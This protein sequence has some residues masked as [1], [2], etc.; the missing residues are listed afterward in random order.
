ML[1]VGGL[2]SLRSS[3]ARFHEH[4]S[5]VLRQLGWRPS[6]ADAD[7]WMKRV[8]D[9]WE[10]LSTYVDDIL[11][12]AKYPM[13]VINKFKSFYTLKGIGEPEYYLGGEIAITPDTK[14]AC[15]TETYIERAVTKYEAI[16]DVPG[17]RLYNTPMAEDYHPC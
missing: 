1:I 16:F 15:S 3:G 11:V 8:D 5:R 6:K 9:H 17:F 2:Y 12:L 10:Y 14:L 13:A 4:Q 7:L